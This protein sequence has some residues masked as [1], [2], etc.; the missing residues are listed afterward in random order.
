MTI[1]RDELTTVKADGTVTKRELLPAERDK[2]LIEDLGF[3]EEIARHLPND[4]PPDG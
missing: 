2:V 1:Q 4:E 3:S